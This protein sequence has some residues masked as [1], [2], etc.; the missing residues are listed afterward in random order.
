MVVAVVAHPADKASAALVGSWVEHDA[1][2]LTS[3]DLRCPGW[4]VRNG[5]GPATAVLAGEPVPDRAIEGVL[6]RIGSIEASELAAIVPE[7]R[8]YCAA[9]MTAFLKWWLMGLPAP[10]INQPTA[11]SLSGPGWR[12]ATWH[13]V[14]QQVGLVC[15]TRHWC[16]NQEKAAHGDGTNQCESDAFTK[17]LEVVT[18]VS[19]D[20]VGSF[21]GA[22]SDQAVLLAKAAGVA[23]LDVAFDTG[24]DPPQFLWADPWVDICNP[25]V[26]NA[27]LESLVNQK[28][29]RVLR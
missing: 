22:L 16:A 13:L 27:L 3:A 5:G 8:E 14:A 4:V 12:P 23:A 6:V 20:T 25:S 19:N 9:E 26:A 15:A 21:D 18:V 24:S 11:A 29:D 28:S 2:L 1:R 17:H 7:D 10:V